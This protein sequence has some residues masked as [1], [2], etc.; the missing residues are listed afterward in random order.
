[1]HDFFIQGF[2]QS[3][4]DSIIEWCVI[5]CL[6]KLNPIE[7]VISLALVILEAM[8]VAILRTASASFLTSY[9]VMR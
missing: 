4:L 6:A 1:M 9:K 2:V 8:Q 7:G 3:S 5:H